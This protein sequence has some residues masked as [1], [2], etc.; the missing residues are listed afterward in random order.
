MEGRTRE[1][2]SWD[3]RVGG[4]HTSTPLG[5]QLCTRECVRYNIG[6]RYAATKRS[7]VGAS[8]AIN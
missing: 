8:T 2:W 1:Q 5:K 7:K 4:A 6:S 3:E